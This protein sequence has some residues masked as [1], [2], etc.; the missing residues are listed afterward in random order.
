[1]DGAPAGV[2]TP[3]QSGPESNFKK[4]ALHIPKRSWTGAL[5]FDGVVSYKGYSLG[6]GLPLCRDTVDIFYTPSALF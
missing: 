2:T 3:G 5:S 6:V 1:M 4:G